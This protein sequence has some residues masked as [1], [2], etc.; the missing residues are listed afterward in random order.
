[1]G[2]DKNSVATRGDR[3]ASKNGRQLAITASAITCSAR[4]LHRVCRVEDY[5]IV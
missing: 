3:G 1:M 4:A 2:L 5:L